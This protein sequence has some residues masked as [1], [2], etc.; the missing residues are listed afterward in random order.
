MGPK[1][2]KVSE[3]PRTDQGTRSTQQGTGKQRCPRMCVKAK[4]DKQVRSRS[5]Q[6]GSSW[7]N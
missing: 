7:E 2:Q 6:N 4:N 1:G 3:E 5:G